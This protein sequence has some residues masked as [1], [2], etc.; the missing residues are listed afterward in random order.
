MCGKQHALGAPLARAHS[1]ERA[2]G[3][4]P[5]GV[6]PEGVALIQFFAKRGQRGGKKEGDEEI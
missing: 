4:E 6:G 2:G 1:F 5:R 3:G